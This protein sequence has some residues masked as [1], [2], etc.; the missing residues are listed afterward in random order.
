MFLEDYYPLS[1]HYVS[2]AKKITIR[3]FLPKIVN[4]N[5]QLQYEKTKGNFDLYFNIEGL[6]IQSEHLANF[7]EGKTIYSYNAKKKLVR[8]ELLHKVTNEIKFQSEF[9]YDTKGRIKT[10]RCY[11]FLFKE[12]SGL[13]QLNHTYSCNLEIINES[14]NPDDDYGSVIIITHDE[15]Q[16][17]IETRSIESYKKR[18]NWY[19][20]VFDKKDQLLR[21]YVFDEFGQTTSIIEYKPNNEKGA[22]PSYIRFSAHKDIIKDDIFQYDEKGNWIS[23]LVTLNGEPYNY[24]ERTIEYFHLTL[25]D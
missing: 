12:C 9:T 25:F 15:T 14:T 3:S 17:T 10:E 1:S 4:G 2:G 6:L 23:Q 20:K 13:S 21:K 16:K 22:T 18:V 11:T 24:H 8:A 19:K 5:L 7:K